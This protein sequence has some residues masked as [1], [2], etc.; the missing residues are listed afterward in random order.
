MTQKIQ[1]ISPCLWFDRQAEEAVEFYISV[2]RNGRIVET[3]RYPKGSYDPAREGEVM[4]VTFEIEGCSLIA[5]NGGAQFPFTEAISLSVRCDGQAEVDR[6]WDGLIEGG[7]KPVQCGWLKDRYGLSWQIVPEA[8][9]RLLRDPDPVKCERV[10]RALLPMVKIDIVA[11]E[12]AY[13]VE[14]VRHH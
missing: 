14:P 2:F 8:L 3:A 12:R 10:M 13:G 11:L 9:Y 5:L 1:K 6:L 7:G 4:I